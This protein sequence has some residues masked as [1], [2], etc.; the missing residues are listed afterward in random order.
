M[1]KLGMLMAGLGLSLAT[2]S[3]FA[4]LDPNLPAEKRA[5]GD[6]DLV[7]TVDFRNHSV[8]RNNL[9]DFSDDRVLTSQTTSAK[10]S[11]EASSPLYND[12]EAFNRTIVDLNFRADVGAN[13]SLNVQARADNI[14]GR[15]FGANDGTIAD[16]GS[17]FNGQLESELDLRQ[18]YVDFNDFLFENFN[19]RLGQAELTYGIDRGDG[20]HFLISSN[21]LGNRFQFRNGGNVDY[22]FNTTAP[23][24]AAATSVNFRDLRAERTPFVWVFNYNHEM[25][26]ADL[27]AAKFEET[28]I[29]QDDEDILGLVVGVPFNLGLNEDEDKNEVQFHFFR[30]SD[31]DIQTEE[32][33]PT[34]T[35]SFGKGS[36]IWAW[37]FGARW[38]PVRDLEL[39]AEFDHQTGDFNENA[40]NGAGIEEDHDA[41]AFYLGAK[42]AIPEVGGAKPWVEASYWYYTGDDDNT[43]RDNEAYINY[44]YAN[45]TL[46]VENNEYGMGLSN[47]YSVFRLE[48]G[49][50]LSN[51]INRPGEKWELMTGLH[52]FSVLEDDISAANHVNGVKS[53]EDELGW[54]WDLAAKW[55][56][57]ENVSFSLGF[58]WFFP[59]DYVSENTALGGITTGGV[60]KNDD[61]VTV[62]RFDTE[63]KF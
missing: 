42:Y 9:T 35:T 8:Y 11:V 51:V 7:I 37:G 16:T 53:S 5:P 38:Y 33:V 41:F 3:A 1:K 28:G 52:F 31:K 15:S 61:T 29:D 21:D 48:G 23:V 44:G 47:N 39:F 46:V 62:V 6:A 26:W 40:P 63:V 49:V 34:A 45:K 43:D 50:D 10:T 13:V 60:E 2:G 27:F 59:G 36:D 58:G 17:T 19:W 22:A 24:A 55:G 4:K 30:H 32:D 57:S 18:A 12:K 54:E 14:A 56:Y 25:F 20:S